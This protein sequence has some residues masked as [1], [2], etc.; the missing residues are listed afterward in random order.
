MKRWAFIAG[1]LAAA[2]G[3]AACIDRLASGGDATEA[4]NARV[5]GVVLGE[6]SVPVAG[7]EVI[8]LPSD[9]N[10]LTAGPVPDSLKVTTDSQG[11]YRFL[12]LAPGEYNV[13][14]HDG[15]GRGR[16]AVWGVR[17]GSD[18]VKVP[19]DTLHATG[20][21][22][23]PMPETLDSDS[24][25]IY[26]PGTL[27]RARIDSELRLAGMVRIDSV[28][29]GTVPT[30][31]CARGLGGPALLLAKNVLVRKAEVSPVD[32]YALW[33]YSRK[34]LLNTATGATALSHD[35]RDFPLLV[36]LAA[37]AFDFSQAGSGGS[38]L[39]FSAADGTPL[40][41]EI[42]SWDPVAGKA[43]VW[44]RLDTLHAG[45]ADQYISMH[46]GP[47]PAA[48][49]MRIR[50]VF[51][52]LAGFA[53]VWHLG[54]E[55]PD[56]VANAL[57]KDVTGAGSDGDD[58]I[59]NT[60]REGNI[61]AGH[62]LDS[63]DY[64]L[65]PRPWSGLRVS[66]TFTLSAWIKASGKK[67]GLQGGEILSAGDNYGIRVLRDSGLQFWYWTVKPQPTI[68]STWNYLIAKTPTVLDGRWHSIM[69]TFDGSFLRVYLDG[70]EVGQ[71]PVTG[72]VGPQ[73]PL[74]VT[75]GRHGSGRPGFEFSGVL[76]E[77]EIHSV[78]RDAEW[79]K[80]SFEN[81]MPASV[82]PAFGL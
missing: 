54:E 8:I 31:A 12:S 2:L 35:L 30:V 49:A 42:E 19:A 33:P 59:A 18:S 4:G 10:P 24:G 17:L 3:L 62:G 28:P 58:H 82:F 56:T 38:D 80:L 70:H 14:A 37:P 72:A 1:A 51:D 66:N 52:T 9:Y 81:Q 44:V 6:D 74:N 25:W 71:I 76:D 22:S 43:A 26:L 53:G 60:S 16:L 36:R 55:A 61:G 78:A 13:L 27:L 65:S 41:R 39:R 32:A 45:Q 50:T 20:S 40:A 48:G 7:A 47:T 11:R 73:F 15:A 5:S 21:L 79:A 57:Y 29:A 75:M 46:W 64:I 68:P 23:V 77:A 69:G 34:V 67:L 63:G